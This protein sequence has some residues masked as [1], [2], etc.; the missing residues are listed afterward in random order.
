[1]KTQRQITYVPAKDVPSAYTLRERPDAVLQK[2]KWL[3]RHDREC[4]D[5]YG[6]LPLIEGMPVML[7][8]H[9]DRNPEKM[10]LRGRIGCIQ[11]WELADDESSAANGPR[12]V[13]QKLPKTV[14]VQFYEEVKGKLVLPTWRVGSLEP[15]VYPVT[16]GRAEW[17]L[18]KGC[19][20]PM[21]NVKRHQLPLSPA[22]AFCHHSSRIAGPNVASCHC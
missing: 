22:L 21:L 7:K 20:H 14:Y 8:D 12:R 19:A 6:M 3:M 5:L 16:P 11:S 10:L 9:V 4:G 18:D 2:K 1:M 15:G 13:L 17:L